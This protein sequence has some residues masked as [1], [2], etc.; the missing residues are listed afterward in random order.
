MAQ[1]TEITTRH[2][3]R[4]R[5]RRRRRFSTFH[6]LLITILFVLAAGIFFPVRHLVYLFAGQGSGQYFPQGEHPGSY[7]PAEP[8]GFAGRL[9]AFARENGLSVTDWPD[10]LVEHAA[11]NPELE[12][13]VLQYPL[14]KDQSP[15]IDLSDC[16]DG[17]TVPLLLQW[18][19]RWGYTTYA[20]N[21]M[22]L[23][24]CGPT[25]LSM[26]CLYLKQDARLTPAYL[27]R[28]SEEHGYSLPGGGS[29]WTLISEGGPQLGLDVIEIPLDKRRVERNLEVGNPV[30]CVM[31]P[32]DFTT[33]GHFIVLTGLEDGKLRVN[34]PNSPIRSARLW[35]FDEIRDQIKNLW[36]CR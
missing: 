10:V 7:A 30:I 36:V 1:R 5:R 6:M 15:E 23:S 19:A 16:T 9:A 35:T 12:E 22:G 4:R 17:K 11:E 31:G 32:G 27:A 18:D 33:T 14:Q 20:D 2:Q 24:G 29:S 3:V 28:F 26:V 8:V 34:D 13:F 21:L 25:C